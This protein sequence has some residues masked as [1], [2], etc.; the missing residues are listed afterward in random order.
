[1]AEL[2]GTRLRRSG[3]AWELAG[4]TKRFPGI[5]AVDRVSLRLSAG[6]I[7]GLVGEN[8]SGK[9]T[10][11]KVLSGAHRPDEGTI[12]RNGSPIVLPDPSAARAAGIATVFQEFSLVPSLT[13]AENIHLGRLPLKRRQVD[14]AR[15]RA[16]A[17]AVLAEMDAA[18]DVDAQIGRLSVA[19][20]QLVEIA[21]A[22]AADASMIILDEPTTALG[23]DEIFRLHALLKRLKAQGKTILYISHRLDEVVELVD[24]VTIMKDGRIASDAEESR[25]DVPFIVRAMVGDVGDH[26]P[27]ERNATGEILL[28]VNGISTHNRIRDVSFDVRRGEVFGLGGVLGSGRTELAR[29]LFGVDPLTG[30]SIE[31]KGRP[32]RPANCREAVAAGI[33]LVPENRKSDG[34][35]FNFAGYPNISIAALDRLGRRG[36][37]SLNREKQEGRRFLR[38]LE[39]S[40][41]AETREVGTL[42]G[43]NQQKIV[44]ARWLFA[45]AD[46]FILDEP[47][48]GIDIGARIA[49]YRLINGVTAA[50]KGVILISSDDDELI[51]MS[52]RIGIMSH[53]CLVGIHAPGDLDATALVRAS[54]GAAAAEPVGAVA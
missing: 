50:G 11:I 28:R 20:Q 48:Q 25:V 7:H 10:L 23:I 46:L 19:E 2:Q 44:I 18:V 4:V 34:L 9:S 30:G 21:K 41:S 47:T 31:L 32:L 54:A 35:F 8:G 45:G 22:L 14:W 16:E 53:G 42:S 51:A 52:D 49:V 17:A 43:G 12:L 39:I 37:I 3:P 6:E 36:L 24:A 26:Y 40:P 1:M 13:A 27:K 29:A 15:I 33:A 5:V 38:D